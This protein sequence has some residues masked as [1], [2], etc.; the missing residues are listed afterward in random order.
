MMFLG[1]LFF[2]YPETPAKESRKV[3]I[4]GKNLNRQ[5]AKNA[6]SNR[7]QIVFVRN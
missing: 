2:S 3:S 4:V 1:M 5:D 6:K 7:R